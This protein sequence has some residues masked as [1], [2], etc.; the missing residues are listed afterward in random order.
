MPEKRPDRTLGGPHDEFWNWC[1]K[2]ELRLQQC[3]GCSGYSWPPVESCE[4][5]GGGGLTW[6]PMSGRG[7]VASWCTFERDYYGGVMPVPYDNILV[8]LEEGVLFLSNPRDFTWRDIVVGMAVELAFT[9]CEDTN[10]R[11]SLPVF[12]KA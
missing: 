6:A 8:E 4:H 12:A 5:C 10:G 11:F 3:S 7:T 2:G 9:E 1:G